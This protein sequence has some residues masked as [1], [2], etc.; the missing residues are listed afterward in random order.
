MDKATGAYRTISEVAEELDIPQHVLRFWETR[1]PQIKPMK[2]SGGRRYYRPADVLLLRG[3]RKLLYGEGYTIKGVQRILIAQGVGV[4]QQAGGASGEE[5]AASAEVVEAAELSV[6]A[7]AGEEDNGEPDRTREG[8]A[9]RDTVGEDFPVEA[10][11][12]RGHALPGH[13]VSVGPAIGYADG[14]PMHAIAP[15]SSL[16]RQLLQGVLA[17]LAECARH[18][19]AVRAAGPEQTV[20]RT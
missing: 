5:L 4:V 19:E 3:I 11:T 7:L 9:G 1:F 8:V 17:E 2:R 16:H 20:H 14:A 10:P 15:L 13:T 6:A 18:L 12:T